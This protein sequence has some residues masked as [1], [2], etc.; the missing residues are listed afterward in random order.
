M[1]KAKDDGQIRCA[2]EEMEF[3]D[4]RD[5]WF[6][7]LDIDVMQCRELSFYAKG[8]Y[9]I[10]CTYMDVRTR[11]WSVKIDTL[12]NVAGISRRQVLYALK[13]LKEMG[14]ITSDKVYK[15]GQQ[16]AAVYT[17]IGHKAPCF[18]KKRVQ[19]VHS[20]NGG[21]CTPC[22]YMGASPA[23]RLLEPVLLEPVLPPI[24]PHG[25]KCE[26]SAMETTSPT[27]HTEAACGSSPSKGQEK[28]TKIRRAENANPLDEWFEKQFWPN[29][30]RHVDK[31]RARNAFM[32]VLAKARS[33]EEQKRWVINMGMRLARYI[34][35]VKETEERFIKHPA[36]WLNAHDFSEPPE[37][38][39]ILRTEVF[40]RDG[41]E[42]QSEY[43]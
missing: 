12:T 1:T 22:T 38:N 3:Y 8:I 24:A 31:K 19:E 25:G 34:Y 14:I 36:T 32:R 28:K 7:H 33:P 29:Y 4:G 39:E 6:V 18:K 40:V 35:D 15:N 16:K 11:S 23:H 43:R 37:E 41:G 21:E 10:L 17:L 30:P 5:F 27:E 9:A 2:D 42:G 26:E 13:E 20:G